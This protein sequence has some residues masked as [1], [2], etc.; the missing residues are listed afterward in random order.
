M[1][2]YWVNQFLFFRVPPKRSAE[3]FSTGGTAAKECFFKETPPGLRKYFRNPGGGLFYWN[4]HM[5]SK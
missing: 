4:I 3:E 1:N 5:D 2:F